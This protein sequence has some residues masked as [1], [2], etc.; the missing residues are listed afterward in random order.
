VRIVTSNGLT[1]V[2]W[3]GKEVFAGATTGPV[4]SHSLSTN[5]THCAAVFNGDKILWES[6]PGA[7]A[8]VKASL[9]PTTKPPGLR[10]SFPAL[11]GRSAPLP[12]PGVGGNSLSVT[13]TNGLTTVSYKGQTVFQGQTHG[14]VAARSKSVNGEDSA[15]VFD[16]DQ[17]LWENAPGAAERVK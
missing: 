13:T 14:S 11:P 16:G 17:V 1:R 12:R 10:P 3:Q 5:G 2:T 9:G 8:L 6:T 4:T 15:A 7:A